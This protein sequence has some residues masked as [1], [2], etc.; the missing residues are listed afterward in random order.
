MTR[1]RLALVDV[2]AQIPDSRQSRGKRHPLHSILSLAIAAMLCGYKSYSAMAEWGRNYGQEFS[3]ALGFTHSKTPCAATLHNI[4]RSLDKQMFE[5]RLGDWVEAVMAD[6]PGEDESLEV[7]NFDGKTL[8]GSRKQGAPAAHLLSAVGQRLG[9][10]VAQQAVDD[11]TNEITVMIEMLKDLLIENRVITMDA[12]LTQRAIAKEIVNRGGD[13]LMVVKDNQAELRKW[14]S[15]LFEQPIWLREAVQTAETK[16]AAHGRIE[17]RKLSAS[18]A[19]NDHDLWPGLEQVLKIERTVIEKKSGRQR[20]EVVFGVTSLR[21]ERASAERL[22][23]I[24]R[25]HWHIENKSHWVRDVTFDEDRSQVRC[26]SIPQIMAA[27]RNTA[28]G[29]MRGAGETNIAAACRRFAAQPWLAL[30]LIG[31]KPE[32]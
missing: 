16:D 7:I 5:S 23:E 24:A 17:A 11:K 21:R 9:L 18:S 6:S 13:Y 28:I 8:R 32:N 12:L 27:I 15:A 26:G 1:Q 14:V 19:L 25:Q 31:I 30:A 10:S 22:I 4:F 2:L 3:K 20:Q 29:L